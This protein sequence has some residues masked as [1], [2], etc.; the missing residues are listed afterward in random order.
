MKT[1]VENELTQREVEILSQVSMGLF[2]QEIAVQNF[3]S[4]H[5]VKQHIKNIYR[6]IGVRNRVEASLKY[7]FH[8]QPAGIY[9]TA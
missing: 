4:P 8:F 2:D 7:L 9:G 3:L 6:K 1:R 5:T